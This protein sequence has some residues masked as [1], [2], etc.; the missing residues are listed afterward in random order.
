MANTTKYPG[1]PARTVDY[2][3]KSP[4][5]ARIVILTQAEYDAISP[6]DP[7]TLYFIRN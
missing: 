3:T 2:T 1:F 5:V 7:N 6:K 4:D